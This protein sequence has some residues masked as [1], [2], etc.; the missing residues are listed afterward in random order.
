MW[1][2]GA[3][4]GQTKEFTTIDDLIDDLMEKQARLS[5]LLDRV[6]DVREAM[7]LVSLHSQNA[8]RLGKLMLNKKALQKDAE[9]PF[10]QALNEVLDEL[11]EELDLRLE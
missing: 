3:Y 10:Q 5:A 9:D 6:M 1:K 2:H 4:E 7:M 11:A 8:A